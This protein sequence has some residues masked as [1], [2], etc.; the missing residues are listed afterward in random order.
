MNKLFL[1][2]SLVL[3]FLA[4]IKAQKLFTIEKGQN[5]ESVYGGSHLEESRDVID[6]KGGFLMSGWSEREQS[7]SSLS[8]DAS[9]WFL[10]H[11]GSETNFQTYGSPEYAEIAEGIAFSNDLIYLAY[12]K[13]SAV[14]MNQNVAL[15][16]S[17][18]ILGLDSNG[19]IQWE[20]KGGYENQGVA[21]KDIIV[22]ARGNIVV[23]VNSLNVK[24]IT[25]SYLLKLDSSGALLYTSERYYGDLDK[26]ASSFELMEYSPDVYYSICNDLQGTYPV[27]VIFSG[28]NGEIVTS[29][30]HRSLNNTVLFGFDKNHS[31]SIIYAAGYSIS[32]GDTNA[33]IAYID[34]SF[35]IFK[36]LKDGR[37]GMEMLMDIGQSGEVLIA[38]GLTNADTEGGL[39]VIIYHINAKDSL[40]L[41][42][43][44]G[45]QFD[46]TFH[47][48]RVNKKDRQV[49][50]PGQFMQLG[51]EEGNAYL[52]GVL[53]YA[54]SFTS[55]TCLNP[56]LA[57]VD[58]LFTRNP[59]TKE[60]N[61]TTPRLTNHAAFFQLV[62]QHNIDYVIMYGADA[63]M[64]QWVL[65]GSQKVGAQYASIIEL[66]NLL[67]YAADNDEGIEFGM[68]MG[69][70]KP[71]YDNSL[72][73]IDD[74]IE[75]ISYL[76]LT[77]NS[78]KLSFFVLEDEFWN[79]G[80]NREVDIQN[81]P[82]FRS[83]ARVQALLGSSTLRAWSDSTTFV[84]DLNSL[85][86]S[87]SPAAKAELLGY[88]YF[89]LQR[90]HLGY[91][92]DLVEIKNRSGNIQF[93][94]DYIGAIEIDLPQ[95]SFWNDN[96]NYYYRYN[97][98]TAAANYVLTTE[99]AQRDLMADSIK[100]HI[101]VD[102]VFLANY[103]F[104]SSDSVNID[105]RYTSANRKNARTLESFMQISP[106][107]K[108]PL[109]PILSAEDSNICSRDSSS[110]GFLGNWLRGSNDLENAET[111]WMNQ[112]TAAYSG[113]SAPNYNSC[114]TCATGTEV[115]AMCWYLLNCIEANQKQLPAFTNY[116]QSQCIS[117]DTH[118]FLSQPE[119]ELK[120][121]VYPNPAK[122]FLYIDPLALID[123]E[124]QYELLD[125]NGRILRK[126]EI[127]LGSAQLEIRNLP[128]GVYILNILQNQNL[129]SFKII[130]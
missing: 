103:V 93:I 72:V 80:G 52:G 108:F 79:L 102:A 11:A 120:W 110:G 78:G 54:P 117:Q 64:N 88:Y 83:S 60:V 28:S 36:E 98:N 92:R 3:A 82:G 59:E 90:E 34:Q 48:M 106:D 51:V 86:S 68:A 39:D 114:P 125:I 130:H 8:V 91:L 22:D 105:F 101:G 53:A 31:E 33:Y 40:D 55:E 38:G 16:D 42:E 74:I 43:T 66:R 41:V 57:Y 9:L 65:N 123:T 23:L 85:D 112:F 50:F 100:T 2:S 5:L 26:G 63:L 12:R 129:A 15:G 62:K 94:G 44:M 81:E 61:G 69:G 67:K 46:E 13:T 56:R 121:S 128:Q 21:P 1:V 73:V 24:N 95:V 77:S 116:G 97:V 30:P 20:Y 37:P 71:M 99:T 111:Q 107:R 70:W 49:F 10:N 17:L 6:Y 29:Y 32:G 7:Q 47:H 127:S 76:N 89:K 115:K 19:E 75:P 104:A 84:E 18:F 14:G 126:S 4:D 25:G 124:Y 45:S 87:V 35:S 122:D 109:I 96:K 27:S 118:V 119:T 113:S 58:G